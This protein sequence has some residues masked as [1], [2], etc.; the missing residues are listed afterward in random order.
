M[1]QT[2]E[3]T[4]MKVAGPLVVAENMSGTKMFEVVRVGRD[5]LVGEIIKLEG[6]TAS[7][8][9]YEDTSGLTVGDP[10]V[11]TG[12]PLSLELGPGIL[13]GIYDGIQRPLEH[14]QKVC[15][16]VFIP[17]GVDVPN[18]DRDKT[19][20][21]KPLNVKVGDLVTG[22]DIVGVLYENGLFRAHYVMVPPNFSGR[23]KTVK[24]AGMYVIE[25]AVVEI[26]EGGKVT[27]V[28]M[29]QKW[30]VRQARPCVEKLQGKGA[31]LT[32]ERVIDA[33]FPVTQGGTAAVPGA[34]GC[35]K[36]VIS[37]ALSKYSN[38]DVIVYVGCGERGNEMAEVLSDFPELTTF[39]DGK[40]EPIMQRTT[41]V[42]NTS[43]MPVAAR[44]ASIYT[45]V[46]TAEFFRDMG[47]NVAMM[48]DSTSRW[49]EALREISGRLAEMPADA[50]YPAYLGAR[51]AAFYER[52]GRVTCLGNPS[53]E[54]SIT[55]VGAVSP[56]GGDFTDPVTSATLS[57]VQ[58]FWGLDKK[59]AQRKH[60]PSVNWNISFSKYIRTLEPYFAAYDEEYG[61][62]QQKMKEILQKEDDLQEIV[63]LVGKDSLSEDQKVTLEVAKII[64]ED[65]LQQNGF[66]D[67]DFKC[68]LAKT[69][70]M[71]RVIVGFHEAA[72]KAIAESTGESKVGWNMIY[73]H[74][75]D[76]V[77]KI[78]NMKFELPGQSEEAFKK[79][80]T[81]LYE[82]VLAAFRTLAEEK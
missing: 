52:S 13:D 66:T 55:I 32:C 77:I 11:K 63:Q 5:N 10:L 71:M 17:R 33:L 41:L 73:S 39:I 64:R 58:V 37:Q 15:K 20:D 2:K 46:T 31:L 1:A 21:Y 61:M 6:D 43:N 81:G 54:G 68:P 4:V 67:Y 80:F 59:L 49:A 47:Y 30:P 34:F 24:P 19:W 70:G 35:G 38:S 79:I 9:V 22:G 72:Q 82:E 51:L 74:M 12:L 56:P 44:E 65:F 18:L 16:S 29:F 14:I 50:G 75:R 76:L 42:A 78:T 26:E 48:A 7:I 23:V 62:L 8:Q 69:I 45:G 27:P 36:T 28:M 25:T 53:R 40:E 3:G 57:I 60:F